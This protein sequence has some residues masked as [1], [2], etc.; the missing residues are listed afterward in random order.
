ME[1]GGEGGGED[2]RGM[3]LKRSGVSWRII[4]EKERDKDDR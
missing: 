4:K 2:E 1:K 3:R